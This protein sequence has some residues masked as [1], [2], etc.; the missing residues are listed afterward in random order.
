MASVVYQAYNQIH[1]TKKMKLFRSHHPEFAD[2]EQLRDFIYV[3]DVVEVIIH[4]MEQRSESGIFNLGTGRAATFLDLVNYT[5]KA[6]NIEPDIDFI[7]TPT[8]IRDNYQYFTEAKME[9]LF[10]AGYVQ[11][12]TSLEDGITDYV[13]HYLDQSLIN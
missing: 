5:F 10:N 6:M 3:K 2:G 7:D 12:F 11:K 9:K 8:D 1:Q 13:Q 4:M